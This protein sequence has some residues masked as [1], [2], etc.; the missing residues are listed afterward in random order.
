M[1]E[2]LD[3]WDFVLGAYAVGLLAIIA[4]VVWSWRE[5]RTAEQRRE[6]SRKK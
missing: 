5:M 1:R 2:T 4:I 3:Q 6:E